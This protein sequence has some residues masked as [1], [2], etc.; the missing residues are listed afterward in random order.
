MEVIRATSRRVVIDGPVANKSFIAE[1]LVFRLTKPSDQ[2]QLFGRYL[3][4][5]MFLMA[6]IYSSENVETPFLSN[7]SNTIPPPLATQVSGSSAI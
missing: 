2:V 1:V 5:N 7:I 4:G 3:M 6:L